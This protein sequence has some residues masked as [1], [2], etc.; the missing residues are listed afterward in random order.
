M[1]A[2]TD[3]AIV[4]DAPFELVWSMTNDVASWPQLFSE[5]ASAEILERDGDTVRFRLT[6]HPDEQGRAWSWVSER[7]PDHASRTV[8]AHRVET[9]NFEFMNIEWTYREVEDGV[10]MRW[11]QDFSMKSTAPAT[12]E[13]MAEHIN[14]NSAIQQQRIKELVERA[15]AERGQAFRVLLKMHIHEGME[16][17]FEETWLRV[18]KVV[19]DHPAN[20]GQ[21]L[22]RS[23]DEKGV[24]YI[25]SDWVSEP[26]FRA[27]E[28]SDAH[29]EHR[30]KL[31]PYRS[32]GSMSTMH[33]AQALV[34][35]AAR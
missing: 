34:G 33:V 9:G 26:E 27:F 19:T 23:A 6:M 11:V 8:R 22:S 1:P 21:W 31:H 28:H 4:I 32:G 5:Y 29:V 10:E 15:A 2:H 25:M 13:Q 14:R 16:Q 12:D 30:K 20:L 24:F 3:N 7:T 17:E 35:R 18:G